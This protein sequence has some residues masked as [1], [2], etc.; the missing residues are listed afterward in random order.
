M[1]PRTRGGTASEPSTPQPNPQ[2]SRPAYVPIQSVLKTIDPEDDWPEFDA[3][4]AEIW[5][6]DGTECVDL[7]ESNLRGPFQIVGTLQVD[8]NQS[9]FLSKGS[10]RKP[11]DFESPITAYA[12]DATPDAEIW[13]GTACGWIRMHPSPQYLPIFA[14][15]TEAVEIMYRCLDIEEDMKDARRILK[16]DGLPSEYAFQD[17]TGLTE[18]STVGLFNFHAKFILAHMH[19]LPDMRKSKL[20]MWLKQRFPDILRSVV[21]QTKSHVNRQKLQTMQQVLAIRQPPPPREPSPSPS[22]P[23]TPESEASPERTILSSHSPK[24]SKITIAMRPGTENEPF[25]IPPTQMMLEHISSQDPARSNLTAPGLSNAMYQD[26]SIWYP[27]LAA[28]IV[29]LHAP[30]VL[31]QLPKAWKKTRLAESL[32]EMAKLLTPARRAKELAAGKTRVQ[33]PARSSMSCNAKAI[34]DDEWLLEAA[35]YQTILRR[36]KKSKAKP[37]AS[38]GMEVGRAPTDRNDMDNGSKYGESAAEVEQNASSRAESKATFHA[39]MESITSRS[40]T[41]TPDIS[42]VKKLPLKTPH[43]QKALPPTL[44]AKPSGKVTKLK[45]KTIKRRSDDL[46][47]TPPHKRSRQL[48]SPTP[49]SDIE[50]PPPSISSTP[51]RPST[52]ESE[53]ASETKGS[54]EIDPDSPVFVPK[55]LNMARGPLGSLRCTNPSCFFLE[56]QPNS[57]EGRERMLNHFIDHEKEDPTVVLARREAELNHRPVSYLMQKLMERGEQADTKGSIIPLPIVRSGV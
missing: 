45:P 51:E 10:L 34:S 17:G 27:R 50:M 19:I 35:E 15:M 30:A 24:P 57:K 33:R 54:E 41:T 12:I 32:Q 6:L 3:T 25:R 7:L 2:R 23:P 42:Y 46:D 52:S 47:D 37:T 8:K 26:F 14:K 20:F 28:A 18:E 49:D 39:F 55:E 4:N 48:Y 38:S 31:E 13:V 43:S 53:S 9:Q 56:R 16:V 44:E 22:S 21:E 29:R 5:T 36:N 40:R 11:Q 1:P